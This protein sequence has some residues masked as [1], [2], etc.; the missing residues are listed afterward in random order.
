MKN[1]HLSLKSDINQKLCKDKRSIQFNKHNSIL[2]SKNASKKAINFEPD[3]TKNNYH[4]NKVSNKPPKYN[5]IPN[6]EIPRQTK[7]LRGDDKIKQKE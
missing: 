3:H 6:L 1:N 4:S 7:S 5:S 2:C